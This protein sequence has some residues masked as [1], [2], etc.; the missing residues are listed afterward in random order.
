MVNYL[1]RL[2]D[3]EKNH[4]AFAGR[5]EVVVAPAVRKLLR[6]GREAP[7]PGPASPA[8]EQ[9]RSPETAEERSGA[10]GD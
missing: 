7:G 9:D 5:R 4:E 10:S 2:G 8:Q 1:Y 3:I 6:A